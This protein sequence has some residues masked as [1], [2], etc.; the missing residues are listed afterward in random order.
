MR[1]AR[2]CA[3]GSRS[4]DRRGRGRL[5][6]DRLRSPSTPGPRG[7]LPRAP[8][9]GLRAEDHGRRARR[10]GRR[11]PAGTAATAA[12]AA[13]IDSHSAL[14]DVAPVRRRARRRGAGQ[15][16]ARAARTPPTA[17]APARSTP[18][19][20][21][22]GTRAPRRCA[23]FLAAP[24]GYS[25]HLLPRAVE[26][27]LLRQEG[28]ATT[29]GEVA[30]PASA[31]RRA[32]HRPAQRAVR[33]DLPARRRAGRARRAP[34]RLRWSR[35]RVRGPAARGWRAWRTRVDAGRPRARGWRS[36]A[37]HD[38]V[39]RAR[40]RLRPDARPPRGRLRLARRAFVADASH[41]LRTPLTAIRGQLR[42]SPPIPTPIPPRSR[43]S[44]A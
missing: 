17:V 12:R 36:H 32:P 44:P 24:P 42:S 5:R 14:A 18:S 41:E 28:R 21:R 15:Q 19:G 40:R 27:R 35:P 11:A 26:L 29:A 6:R 37:R 3:P 10:D 43:G 22:G 34:G 4:A 25:F 38:E 8:A 1:T 30:R 31:S 39:A 7:E 23:S 16:R 9:S 33:D 13:P 2:A 20:A